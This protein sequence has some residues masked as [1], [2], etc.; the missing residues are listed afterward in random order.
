MLRFLVAIGALQLAYAVNATDY[1]A[2]LDDLWLQTDADGSDTLNQAE[3]ADALT[4]LG[5]TVCT[6]A[7][8]CTLNQHN[9]VP[10]LFM[11]IDV[12]G[13]GEITKTELAESINRMPYYKDPLV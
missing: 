11:A 3:F 1:E 10:A 8:A 2:V 6:T 13:D 5:I 4:K 12:S 9:D 7:P